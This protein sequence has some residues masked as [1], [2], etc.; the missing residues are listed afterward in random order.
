MRLV[1]AFVLVVVCASTASA[2]APYVGASF[3]GDIVRVS[4]PREGGTGSGETFGGAL[5]AGVP[6]GSQWGVEL[7]FA[8]TGT[9]EVL[10]NNSCPSLESKKSTKSLAAFGWGA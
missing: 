1:A 6:L 3:I 9:L 2:Q 4:G 8:R 5:R 10:T 7:E